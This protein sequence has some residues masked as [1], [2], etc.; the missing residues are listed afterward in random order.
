MILLDGV[1]LMIPGGIRQLVEED[2]LS[3][4]AKLSAAPSVQSPDCL[5]M[6]RRLELVSFCIQLQFTLDSVLRL[7]SPL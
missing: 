1:L 6:E 7:A 4:S 5:L 3:E 2:F